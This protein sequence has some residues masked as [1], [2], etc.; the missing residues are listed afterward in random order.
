ML[1]AAM[2]GCEPLVFAPSVYTPEYSVYVESDTEWTGTVNGVAVSG[3]SDRSF[4][5]TIG[6]W[7]FTKR[8]R[9]G[10][11]RAFAMPAGYGSRASGIPKYGDR[12]TTDAFGTVA[13]CLT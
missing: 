7:S 8:T 10:L 2:M 6:C 3:F 13:G 4:P 12:A 5:I 9:E 11:I 1:A